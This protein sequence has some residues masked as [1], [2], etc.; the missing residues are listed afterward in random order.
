MQY[1]LVFCALFASALSNWDS[2][3]SFFR[4]VESNCDSNE[5]SCK[6]GNCIPKLQRC[7]GNNDCSDNSDEEECGKWNLLFII[8]RLEMSENLTKY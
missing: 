5:F 3:E 6:N 1:F 8:M 7:N 4:N 2:S